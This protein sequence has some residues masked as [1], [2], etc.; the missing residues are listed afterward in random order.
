MR[1]HHV[2]AERQRRLAPCPPR[3][4]TAR[5]PIPARC[6]RRRAA[7]RRGA[8]RAVCVISVARCAKPP[9]LPYSFAA[10]REIETGECV[11][12]RAA[13]RDIELA[14][15]RLARQMWRL[16]LSKA[17]AE[18]DVR[19]A[20]VDRQ[21]LR[22]AVG[23]VQKADVAERRQV[24][25]VAVVGLRARVTAV[26]RQPRSGGEREQVDEF[27][28]RHGRGSWL[29]GRSSSVVGRGPVVVR[30]SWFVT[31]ALWFVRQKPWLQSCALHRMAQVQNLTSH[32]ARRTTHDVRPTTHD[33]RP[34]PT[35][36][37]LRTTRDR[38]PR[39]HGLDSPTSSRIIHVP[40]SPGPTSR[41]NGLE[42]FLSSE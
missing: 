4:S 40:F 28:A 14:Q 27:P 36:H 9:T 20:I 12:L 15:Q 19:L 18:V 17:G 26:E 34:R 37:D 7:A 5:W 22:M 3:G 1:R 39:D 8:A 38:A 41:V 29:V 11:S 30:R 42:Y 33:V 6:R 16:S 10:W 35:T 13:T 21:Q 31:G 2:H 32:D 25:E 24:V 23:E